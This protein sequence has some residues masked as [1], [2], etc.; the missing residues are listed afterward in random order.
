MLHRSNVVLSA[1]SAAV[2]LAALISTASANRIAT[3]SRT[4]RATWSSSEFIGF[5]GGVPV[6]CAVTIEGSFHS[7]R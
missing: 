5:E 1:L 7:R 6:S 2:V 3:S 4:F